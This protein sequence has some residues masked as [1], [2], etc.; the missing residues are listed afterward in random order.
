MHNRCTFA[1]IWKLAYP[2][3]IMNV[4]LTIMHFCDR[5]FLAMYSSDAVAA[6]LPAGILSYTLI[7]FFQLLIAYSATII[8]QYFGRGEIQSCIRTCWNAFYLAIA[9]FIF[10]LVLAPWIGINIIDHTA[11]EH[12]ILLLEREYFITLIP[13]GFFM[14]LST[15]LISFFN[16][17]GRT[18]Y[19]A[20]INLI[21]VLINGVLDYMMIFGIGGFPEMG[22]RGAGIATSIAC[23]LNFLITLGIF[24]LQNQQKYPTRQNRQYAPEEIRRLFKFGVPSALQA[25]SD[26]GAFALFSF[27]IGF[28][29]PDAMVITTV[30]L[31][32]N[33][34]AFFP[35]LG[36]AESGAILTGQII[37]AKHT[38]LVYRVVKRVWFLAVIYM[39]F[40]AI[41]YL[42]LPEWLIEQF[43]PNNE[44]ERLHFDTL[45]ETGKILLGCALCYNFFDATKFVIM[46]VLRGAGDTRACVIINLICAW[47]VMIP[48]TLLLILYLRTGI[49]TVWVYTSCCVVL[50]ASIMYLRFRSE[51]WKQIRV[52]HSEETNTLPTAAE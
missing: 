28:I 43:A 25:L 4:G 8:A 36:L 45:L 52:I 18:C 26:I 50:E 49:V 48:G 40:I 27:L 17:L 21:A 44:T 2:L 39:L 34:L 47:G 30:I 31:T 11:H 19:A 24:L 22:I 7:C 23:G 6:A 35:M 16:G 46:S 37:G 13:S 38:N 5:K 9:F 33:N 41:F 20:I 3:I 15:S 29:N 1:G 42:L 10:T 51:R 32:I 12:R 14:C